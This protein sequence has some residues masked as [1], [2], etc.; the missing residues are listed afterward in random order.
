MPPFTTYTSGLSAALA[1]IAHPPMSFTE[2]NEPVHTSYEH[3]VGFWAC[4]MLKE[5]FDSPKW[6]ITP[7]RRVDY[8]KKKP[9]LTVEEAVGTNLN[10]HLL[11]E[12]KS[13]QHGIR[14][15]DALG[16]VVR[17]IK[18]TLEDQIECFIVV[19]CGTRIG[20][21]EYHNDRGNLYE[22]T[23]PYF[24]GCVSMTQSYEIGGKMTT[25]LEDKPDDLLP[26]YH[27]YERLRGVND[28]YV[29]GSRRKAGKYPESCIFDLE[30][31]EREICWLFH[32]IANN[33]PRTSVAK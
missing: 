14:F 4:T 20:F 10:L 30:K 19:Q 16:Q 8:T 7:E 1:R 11:V 23:I 2:Q 26:L 17:H 29:T 13:N 6:V 22:E 15:E 27:D 32:Y 24:R 9:D 5:V 21:F 25:I 12:L 28:E 31:H 33:K 3:H 18:E